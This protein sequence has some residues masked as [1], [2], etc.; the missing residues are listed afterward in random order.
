MA[1]SP[2][3]S[4]KPILVHDIAARK[5]LY[6]G[7]LDKE[8]A[9][10]GPDAKAIF[11]AFVDG[12]NAF[13]ALT[14]SGEQPL[15]AEFTHTG[16][17]PDFWTADEAVTIRFHGLMQNVEE[18]V[19]RAR[20]RADGAQACEQFLGRLQPPLDDQSA[21]TPAEADLLE[22]AL[23]VYRQAVDP[24]SF[25]PMAS[26]KTSD[27]GGSNAWAISGARTPSGKPILASDPHRALSTPSLRY[28][29]GLHAPGLDLV[30]GG[31]PM[32]PGVSIGHNGTAAFGLTIFPADQEDFVLVDLESGIPV[33][34]L[35]EPI[36]VRGRIG[37]ADG[38][39]RS[40]AGRTHPRA[41]CD[42]EA[43][44][45]PA[46]GVV[47]AGRISL[48]AEPALPQGKIIHRI[49]SCSQRNGAVPR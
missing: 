39:S 27:P 23:A 2:R 18:E 1:A 49:L 41:R 15:P 17:E 5:V 35:S 24:I 33:T 22:A 6:R 13:I 14:R 42:G 45:R 36:F 9:A 19:A 46:I 26:A 10:Y 7:D 3:I 16:T 37:A 40:H 11:G 25:G 12:V 31:E 43:R 47:R 4:A 30:G 34:R 21:F 8:W 20:L 29:V 44:R 28:L 48:S 32:Q 38:R